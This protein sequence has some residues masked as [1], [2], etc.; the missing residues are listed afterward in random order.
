M[1]YN[2]ILSLIDLEYLTNLMLKMKKSYNYINFKIE[3]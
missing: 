2:F 3:Y 1:Y